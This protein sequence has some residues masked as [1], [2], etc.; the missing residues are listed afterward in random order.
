MVRVECAPRSLAR[1]KSTITGRPSARNRMFAG[2]RSRCTMPAAWIASSACAI[3]ADE[4]QRVARG[5]AVAD[6]ARQRARGQEL[7]GDVGKLAGEAL[8]VDLATY[9]LSRLAS[10]LYSRTKRSR[11]TRSW[12]SARSSTLS[13]TLHAVVLALGEVHLRLAALADDV[14]NVVSR[15][16]VRLRHR[17]ILPFRRVRSVRGNKSI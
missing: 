5:D 13:A 8:V 15:H 1:P 2:L 12:R 11:K 10:S 7:H 6:A 14:N 9:G 16:R 3:C 4:A 17:T